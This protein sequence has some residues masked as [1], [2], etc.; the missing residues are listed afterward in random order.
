MSD[1]YVVRERYAYPTFNL[2][3]EKKLERIMNFIGQ[4]NGVYTVGRQGFFKYINIDDVLIMG[5]E[6]AQ[7]IVNPIK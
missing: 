1:F 6:T 2:G 5:F 4:F 3:Y 7:K